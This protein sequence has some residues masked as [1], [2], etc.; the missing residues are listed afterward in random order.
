M[1]NSLPDIKINDY[2][3]SLPTEKIAQYPLSE[4]DKSK[5]LVYEKGNI[6]EKKFNELPGV[7]PPNTLL[8]FNKTRV[9]NARL[10]FKNQ[11]GKNIEIFTLEPAEQTELVTALNTKGSVNWLCL[12]GNLKA[13]KGGKLES[14]INTE[15]GSITLAAELL[16]KKGDSFI[17]TLSWQ[18]AEKTFAE[19]LDLFGDV[20]L[21]P[22]MKRDSETNDKQTYQTVYAENEGSVAAPT[23]GL[24]FTEKV[25]EGL[26][27]NNIK[28]DFVTLHVGA[29]T[30]KPVKS[31][32]ITAHEMHSES[33][34]IDKKT[35]SSLLENLNVNKIIAVGTTSMRTIESLYWFGVQ[36]LQGRHSGNEVLI[37]QWEPYENT[38]EDVST[39]LKAVLEYINSASI[40]HLYGK[41]NIIIV[42]GY[43]FKIFS[44]LITNFHQPQST[45][46]LLIAAF[47]GGDW[48]RVYEYALNNDFRFLSYGDSSILLK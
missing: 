26:R 40:E 30:F 31:E 16:E 43:D 15:S 19:I 24:H 45:L 36:L 41:T 34:Y 25:F 29:G 17:V 21:P 33:F 32:T 46:L 37:S 27:R 1:E 8:I 14:Q 47:I 12:V 7:I 10:R 22:Y 18:P 11:S 3:Y 28:T 4:R 5:L 35:I 48:K 6:S 39:A 9:I 2:T 20:P 23:A 13:W 38:I 42:P 44:G